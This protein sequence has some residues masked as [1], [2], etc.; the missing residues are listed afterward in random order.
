[1]ITKASLF[2]IHGLTYEEKIRYFMLTLGI[3][4]LFDSKR[5]QR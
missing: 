2:H 4:H 5:R 3:V 1:L